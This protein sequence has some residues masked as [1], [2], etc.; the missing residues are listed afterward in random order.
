MICPPLKKEKIDNDKLSRITSE[1][2]NK[3]HVLLKHDVPENTLQCAARLP[4]GTYIVAEKIL[5]E[6]YAWKFKDT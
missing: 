3:G 1:W 5:E 2:V 4:N 6:G